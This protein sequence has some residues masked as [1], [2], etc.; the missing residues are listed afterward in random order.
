MAYPVVLHQSVFLPKFHVEKMTTCE[1]WQNPIIS[2]E[3]MLHMTV[4]WGPPGSFQ[5][6]YIK[7]TRFGFQMPSNYQTMKRAFNLRHPKTSSTSVNMNIPSCVCICM[8]IGTYTYRFTGF[9]SKHGKC[10]M[11][12]SHLFNMPILNLLKYPPL[13]LAK[14]TTPKCIRFPSQTH[15]FHHRTQILWWVPDCGVRSCNKKQ[16]RAQNICYGIPGNVFLFLQT[17]SKPHTNL[18][19]AP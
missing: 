1:H 19:A 17:G 16:G 6:G 2:N 5:I 12:T 3:K 14:A 13:G 18:G 7:R 15:Y 8:R 9:E 10:S 11:K 4:S